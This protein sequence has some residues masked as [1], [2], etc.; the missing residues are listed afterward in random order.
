MEGLGESRE[1]DQKARRGCGTLGE[2]LMGLIGHWVLW[3]GSAQ[4]LCMGKVTAKKKAG[5]QGKCL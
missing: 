5:F 3:G 4:S 2:R 1:G